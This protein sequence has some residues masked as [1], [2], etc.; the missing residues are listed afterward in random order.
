MG[1]VMDGHHQFYVAEMVCE[2]LPLA[3]K[4]AAERF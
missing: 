1:A 4:A 2:T 3:F